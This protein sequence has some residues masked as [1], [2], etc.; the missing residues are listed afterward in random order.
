[1]IRFGRRIDFESLTLLAMA[2]VLVIIVLTGYLV[3]RC[4]V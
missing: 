3:G 4:V 1:M 2:P